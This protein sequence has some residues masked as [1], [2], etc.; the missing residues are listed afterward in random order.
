MESSRT[1]ILM[2]PPDV[3][4][5]NWRVLEVHSP[6]SHEAQTRHVIGWT[7][8]TARVSSPV[9]FVDGVLRACMTRSGN[10]YLLTGGPAPQFDQDMDELLR[11]WSR[12][13]SITA[14]RDVTDEVVELFQ[15]IDAE[16]NLAEDVPADFPND[17]FLGAVPGSQ[18][19]FLAREIDGR[20]V[21]GPTEAELKERHSLC[22]RLVEQ[23]R[24]LHLNHV[25]ATPPDDP[26]APSLAEIFAYVAL[27]GWNLS[28]QERVWIVKKIES[29]Q[30]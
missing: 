28:A 1:T 12:A 7:Q 21:V 2:K 26:T 4:L 5:S 18:L 9:T 14:D 30:L 29:R 23:F 6:P 24:R 3:L 16:L 10:V 17:Y 19:K 25:P 22:L 15:Q 13:N 20:Y 11:D 8:Y 27:Q